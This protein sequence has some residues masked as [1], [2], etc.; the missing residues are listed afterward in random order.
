MNCT[1]H[2][3]EVDLVM[4]ASLPLSNFFHMCTGNGVIEMQLRQ[5]N[6]DAKIDLEEKVFN[7]TAHEI[8][9]K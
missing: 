1:F 7:A 4:C 6:M 9:S 3:S 8:H 2:S 5:K